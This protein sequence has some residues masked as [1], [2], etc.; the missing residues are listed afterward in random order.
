MEL[1][2]V[3]KPVDGRPVYVNDR[4]LIEYHADR[5]KIYRWRLVDHK[6]KRA[7]LRS[8]LTKAK[9]VAQVLSETT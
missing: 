1:I 8:S 3:R 7:Y 2:W 5:V 6:T 4:F 9:L